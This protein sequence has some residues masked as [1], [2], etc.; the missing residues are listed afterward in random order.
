[1]YLNFNKREFIK[2]SLTFL[3]TFVL[4]TSLGL[5]LLNEA[6][7]NKDIS[8]FNLILMFSCSS[9]F[10]Y[11]MI[12]EFNTR[13]GWELKPL[14]EVGFS[15]FASIILYVI[16][17]IISSSL[18]DSNIYEDKTNNIA[19]VYATAHY[20]NSTIND[21]EKYKNVYQFKKD[22]LDD[23]VKIEQIEIKAKDKNDVQNIGYTLK[24]NFKELSFWNILSIL[25]LTDKKLLE[26]YESKIEQRHEVKLEKELKK[27]T[28][29][30]YNKYSNAYK[31]AKIDFEAQQKLYNTQVNKM[32]SINSFINRDLKI[33]KDIKDLEKINANKVPNQLNQKS[34]DFAQVFL[35]KD[36]ERLVKI[37]YNIKG[38]NPNGGTCSKHCIS[39]A[40]K[41]YERY[42]LNQ[43]G[44]PYTYWMVERDKTLTTQLLEEGL[45]L[46]LT[47][48]TSLLYQTKSGY[49]DANK[50]AD[51]VDPSDSHFSK[52]ASNLY[53]ENKIMGLQGV[54][55]G[56]DNRGYLFAKLNNDDY[57]RTESFR[58]TVVTKFKKQAGYE[59][60]FNDIINESSFRE[61]AKKYHH[62]RMQVKVKKPVFDDFLKNYKYQEIV[63]NALGRLYMPSKSEFIP[64]NLNNKELADKYLKPAIIDNINRIE[65]SINYETAFKTMI[66]PYIVLVFVSFTFLFWLC[67]FIA[68]FII[69][70]LNFIKIEIDT[71]KQYMK[72]F[73]IKDLIVIPIMFVFFIMINN[74]D[75]SKSTNNSQLKMVSEKLSERSFFTNIGIN[76][77]MFMY[78]IFMEVEDIKERYYLNFLSDS[79]DF[80]NTIYTN[81]VEM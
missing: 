32:N 78:P 23:I 35:A 7:S 56:M 29:S 61:R 14:T 64:I 24:D 45:K 81:H 5:N 59:I 46:G 62:E 22:L 60:S 20:Y 4:T 40:K 54:V 31:T 10:F 18:I 6:N 58:K 21:K 51:Y 47:K 34:K 13:S 41:N 73:R 37:L 26:S 17:N 36:K 67:Y 16:L 57:T 68:N 75:L 77:V 30:V 27:Y 80:S 33:L 65:A 25:V 50:K 79:Y 15:F 55:L 52:M 3:S 72:Y 38:K 8:I 63:Q 39:N 2:T 43:Y 74:H 69:F 9:L 44:K 48:G 28:D 70:V 12:N 71:E 53:L 76:G 49:M 42:F 11:M 1:M 19:N 66:Y